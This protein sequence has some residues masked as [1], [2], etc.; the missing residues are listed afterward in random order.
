MSLEAV[1]AIKVPPADVKATLAAGE[2]PVAELEDATVV[3]LGVKLTEASP[4]QLASRLHELLGGLLDRHDHPR[5]VPVFPASYAPEATTF[6]ALVEELGEA[7]DWIAIDQPAEDDPM[8][9]MAG[10]LGGAGVDLAALQQQ[11]ASGDPSALMDTALQLAQQLAD[12]GKLGEVQQAM[13]GMMGGVDPR[14]MLERSGIDVGAIER[15][16][17]SLDA[18]TLQRL[19]VSPEQMRRAL[20]EAGGDPRAALER[21]GL[22]AATGDDDGDGGDTDG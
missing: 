18:E 13:A 9:A 20:E 1:A 11:M 16:V 12:S 22:P 15:R 2:H 5:G 17:A 8:A 10:L 14:E 21:L 4:E 7:A 3:R 19:G 6:D